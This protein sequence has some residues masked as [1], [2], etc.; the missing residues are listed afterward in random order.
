[1]R[2]G[3]HTHKLIRKEHHN[4]T[5]VS[6]T[7]LPSQYQKENPYIKILF[8]LQVLD[9]NTRNP[10]CLTI[11]STHDLLSG[12]YSIFDFPTTIIFDASSIQNRQDNEQ[13]TR[14]DGASTTEPSTTGSSLSS[15]L[16]LSI[17]SIFHEN[18]I[19]SNSPSSIDPFIYNQRPVLSIRLSHSAPTRHM[20]PIR[21]SRARVVWIGDFMSV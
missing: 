19:A 10:N 4:D 18:D 11:F 8:P 6:Q 2:G 16:L 1:V 9:R 5:V 14:D 20:G 15:S 3:T 12:A 21:N 13:T 7:R 17:R